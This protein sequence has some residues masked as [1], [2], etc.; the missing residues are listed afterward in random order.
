MAESPGRSLSGLSPWLE[1][2]GLEGPKPNLQ[3]PLANSARQSI[4]AAVDPASPD[5]LNFHQ[6]FAALS[7]M[8]LF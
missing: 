5:F 3:A 2:A 8:P 6:R 4:A 1:A 7:S